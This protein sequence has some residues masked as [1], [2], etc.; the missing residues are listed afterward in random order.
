MLNMFLQKIKAADSALCLHCA[1][2]ESVSHY[3]FH[4]HRYTSQQRKMWY[5][6]GVATTSVPWVLSEAEAIPHT[7]HYIA[8]TGRFEKYDDVGSSS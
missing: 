3:L 8:N 2:P 6:V 7:L 5:K 1:S 4:C